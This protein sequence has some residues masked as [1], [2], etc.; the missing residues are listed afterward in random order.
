ML[1][2]DNLRASNDRSASRF[3][4]PA[5]WAILREFSPPAL[6]SAVIS[7]E[8]PLNE[9]IRTLLRMESLYERAQFFSAR[10]HALEHHAALLVLFEVLDVAGRADLKSELMQELERQ[11]QTLSALRSNPA[12]SESA[13]NEILTEIDRAV[14]DL[15][16]ASGKTGQELRENEWL[17]GI[18]Q[19]ASIPGGVCEFDVPSYHHW[20]HQSPDL[21]RKDLDA[22]LAPFLPLRY[23]IA[24][25]LRILRES[26]RTSQQVAAQGVYQQMMGGRVAQLLR[27]QMDEGYD[28]VPEVSANKYALNI[29]FTVPGDPQR[30][31]AQTDVAFEL[32]FCNL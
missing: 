8:F 25:I 3:L 17:M 31:V 24:I 5:I 28:C 30:R 26:G 4:F 9:R 6:W 22:W 19:R 32:T 15:F 16:Q 18:K 2:I 20:L 1:A 10:D 29:R 11:K 14:A 12:I 13:L 27:L 23:G 7:Y 21:R